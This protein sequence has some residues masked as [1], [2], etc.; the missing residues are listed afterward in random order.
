M[1]VILLKDVRNVGKKDEVKEVSDGYARNYLIKR[2]LAVAYTE[3]AKKVLNAQ[4]KEREKEEAQKKAEAE[5]TAEKLKNMPLEFSLNAGKDGQVFGSVSSK[6]I[7]EALHEKG[8]AVDKRKIK[9]EQAISSLGTTK[10][11]VDLY[12]NQVIGEIIV[13]VRQK[14]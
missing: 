7:A 13:R 9:M 6:Q 12:R 5:E 14:D 3:G 8:I 4:L 10:V 1:K 2:H 11:K